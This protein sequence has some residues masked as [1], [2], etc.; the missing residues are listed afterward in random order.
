MIGR[1]SASATAVAGA[2]GLLV[3]AAAPGTP[4]GAAGSAPPDRVEVPVEG[5]FA[6]QDGGTTVHG[7]VHAVRRVEGATAVYYSLGVQ[8]GERWRPNAL[9]P[10]P[11]RFVPYRP[12]DAAAVT[13]VDTAGL[14]YYEV[15]VDSAG[16]C[17]CPQTFDLGR[18]A[19][20]LNVAWAL[21]PPLPEDVDTVAVRV[22]G[23]AVVEDVPVEDGALEPT[24]D[25]PSTV[26]GQGWPALP[27]AADVADPQV[28]VRALVRNVSDREQTVTAQERPGRVDESLAADVLF[29]VDSATLTPQAQTTLRELGARLRE[30]AEG[31]VSVVGHTD[32][33]GEAGYNEQLSLRRAQAVVAALQPLAGDA[34]QLRAEG[35]G[36]REPVADEATAEGRSSNRRV[37]VTYAVDAPGG[38]R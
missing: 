20:V 5:E 11:G 30:R 31:A 33:T 36:E 4:A 7:A 25:A 24:E 21:L 35:R 34:V 1:R 2:A 37:S 17:L 10:L 16:D 29:A 13:L 23:A 14:A 32:T 8:E 38:T 28:F 3:L 6:F 19:A 18:E 27:D 22:A 15:M 9:L 26:L 12:T